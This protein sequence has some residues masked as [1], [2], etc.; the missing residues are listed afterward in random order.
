MA[1]V[2]ERLGAVGGFGLVQLDDENPNSAHVYL[3]DGLAK[4]LQGQERTR[5]KAR[6]RRD[7]QQM[8]A[9]QAASRRRT[10]TGKFYNDLGLMVSQ[11]ASGNGIRKPLGSLS[12]PALRALGMVW[13][14]R[15]I[16]NA[17]KS[18]MRRFAQVCEAP[19]EQLGFR[20]VHRKYKNID[21][22]TDNPD[23]RRRC[24][25]M[26]DRLKAVTRPIHGGFADILENMIEEEL[27][28]DRRVFITPKGRGGKIVSYHMVDG[29][30]IRPRLEVLANWMILNGIEDSHVAESRI[31]R[32][33]LARP[34]IDIATGR[35]RTVNFLD[36]AYV[37]V[38]NEAVVDAWRA[39]DIH[40]AVAHPSIRTNHWGYG[41]SALEHSWGLSMLFMRAMRYNQNLF[42]VNYPEAILLIPGG[43]DEEGLGA[44]KRNVFDLD[45]EEASTRLP[46]V[47]G[48]DLDADAFKPEL[49][50]LRDTPKDMLMTELIRFVCNL[51]C[52][53]Y[54][55]HPSEINVTPDGQGGAIVNVDQTQGDEISDATERGFHPLATGSAEV[56]TEV[57]IVP[58]CDDLMY[59]VEGLDEEGEQAT[60]ARVESYAAHSTFNELRAMRDQKPTPK[61]IPTDPGDFIVNPDYLSIVQMMQQQA[62]AEAQQ[63]MGSYEQGNFGEPGGGGDQPGSATQGGP[64]GAP[65][66]GQQ[67]G[68]GAPGA[69]PGVPGG[70]PPG[71]AGPPGT[72]GAAG[73]DLAPVGPPRGAPRP[74]GRQGQR[75]KNPLFRSLTIDAA[76]VRKWR[77]L[78]GDD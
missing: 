28:L 35:P 3:P 20:C 48:I 30:T 64:G 37:Q 10:G 49:L 59:I 38:M 18:Q 70:A 24:K 76:G 11:E 15:L 58:E 14:D 62:Q 1:T 77:E 19:G 25:E 51:K 17:R 43:Y 53:A 45:T 29:E 56:L 67:M 72:P 9:Q 73:G 57:L 47:S 31:Q 78:V 33:L 61:G 74:P 34:P 55:M 12:F 41:T 26:D 46:I 50:R 39:E 32:D 54:G 23:I 75:G 40:V 6:A 36:A 65:V 7:Y 13:I 27:V 69:G 68:A 52:A 63:S 22:D 44:F 66:P 60:A 2:T 21:F 5:V 4:A 16:I 71:T 42:D 8:I